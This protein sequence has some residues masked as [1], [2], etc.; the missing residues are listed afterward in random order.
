MRM[1]ARR[2]PIFVFWMAPM[3]TLAFEMPW[4]RS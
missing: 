2:S 3:G 1:V 4:S